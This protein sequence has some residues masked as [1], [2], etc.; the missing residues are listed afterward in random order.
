MMGSYGGSAFLLIYLLFTILLAFPALV[1][2]MSLGKINGRGTIAA[3]S[4]IFMKPSGKILGYVLVGVVTIAGSYYAVVVA[5]VLFTTLFSI[6]AGFSEETIN[7]YQSGLGDGGIQY[8]LTVLLI[9]LA[10]VVSHLG[11]KRGIERISKVIMPFFLLAILYMIGYAWT[12]PDTLE[13]V[14]EFLTPDFSSVGSTQVFAALGQAF[15]SVG[16][17]GTFVIVYS[18]YISDNKEIPKVALLTCLGDLGSSLLVSLFLVPCM[19][20][21]GIQMNAGP[22]LIFNTLP[23]LFA[24]LPAGRFIGSLFL[25]SLCLVAFLSLVAAFQVPLS[26]L[27][28]KSIPSKRL[29]IIFGIIQIV[30]ACPSAFYPQIIGTLDLIFGSGFQVFG[31]LLAILGV[32]WGVRNAHYHEFLFRRTGSI[33]SLVA[34]YWMRFA[35]PATLLA[36]LVGYLYENF[37]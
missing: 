23:E 6:T 4:S 33:F 31:S 13:K 35:I 11:L 19:L 1:T 10:L 3:F 26:S 36:V 18:S 25:A 30:I 24:V 20:V 7:Q 12:L 27:R 14:S 29:I 16:L 17:G 21:F 37:L 34:R 28:F 9:V 22:S 15:F 8:L 32:W 2:E 5:N